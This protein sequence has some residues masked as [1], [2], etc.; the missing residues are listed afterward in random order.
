GGGGGEGA[1]GGGPAARPPDQ[2]AEDGRALSFPSAP[3]G[4]PVEI[5][6]RPAA[7]LALAADRP[8]ALV[9]VR[10]CDVLEDGR[11]CLI[12]RGL[13]NLTHRHGH[14]QPVP[15][16]PGEPMTVRVPMKAI[17]QVVPAGHR[18]RLSVSATYWRGAWPSPEPV[19]LTV[20]TGDCA[21]ELPVRPAGGGP[22]P[23]PFGP[24]E[25]APRPAAE[26]LQFEPAD[27]AVAR[28]IAAGRFEFTH[29]DA[30]PRVLLTEPGIEGDTWGPDVF[31][32][33]EDEPLS[34]GGRCGRR[35]GV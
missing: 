35:G 25:L 29:R 24:P 16:V 8:L 17:G 7:V 10:L 34:A 26:I 27:Q 28:S 31:T 18:L 33:C 15:V 4:E 13:L 20:L 11:S 30:T 12:T 19:E 32:I 22:E 3:L 21:L 6:G 2:R 23:A 9:V 14:D 5:L 1:G